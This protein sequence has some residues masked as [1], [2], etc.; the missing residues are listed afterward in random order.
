MKKLFINS[1]LYLYSE[2]LL[3]LEILF[4]YSL[5]SLYEIIKLI[6]KGMTSLLQKLQR[7]RK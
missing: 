5:N 3:P 6:L 7:Q 4:M 1:R 2:G